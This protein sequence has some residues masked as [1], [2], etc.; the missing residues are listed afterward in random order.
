MP[1]RE[2]K[3][4]RRAARDWPRHALVTGQHDDDRCAALASRAPDFSAGVATRTGRH[5]RH[6]SRRS[7][8][9]LELGLGRVKQ[10]ASI[11]LLTCL[12]ASY[13]IYRYMS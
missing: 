11:L 3:T 12:L 2:L 10:T 9:P 4:P 5:R 13:I 8:A 1:R 7:I 6:L